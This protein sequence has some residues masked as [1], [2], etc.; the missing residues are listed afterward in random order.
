METI[1]KLREL[2]EVYE[3]IVEQVIWPQ[4][5]SL[6]VRIVV[7]AI[8]TILDE[9][10]RLREENGAKD[11]ALKPFADCCEQIGDEESDEEWAK[12]RLL[13]GD[14]R[15]ARTALQGAKHD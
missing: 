7:K 3:E 2:R 4:D 13:I 9:L 10:E 15:R 12:F 11:A 5:Y 1:E 8:P 14:Y 6:N